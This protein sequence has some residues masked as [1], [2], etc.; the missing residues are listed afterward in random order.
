MSK[1][2]ASE[3]AT[4]QE[5]R[6]VEAVKILG[7][8]KGTIELEGKLQECRVTSRGMIAGDGKRNKSLEVNPLDLRLASPVS[9]QSEPDHG[10]NAAYGH[11]MKVES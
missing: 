10:I 4:E 5:A 9:F 6:K 11:G 3:S 8:N 2:K 7:G 1:S